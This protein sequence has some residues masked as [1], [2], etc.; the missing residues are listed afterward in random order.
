MYDFLS[1]GFSRG[2]IRQVCEAL[3][4][5]GLS[6][7]I[8]LF[9]REAL[10]GAK[11]VE[12]DDMALTQVLEREIF[13]D[14]LLVRIHRYFWWT[15]LAPWE[16]EFP[17]PGSLISTFLVSG[18]TLFRA[19]T[20]VLPLLLPLLWCYL[21]IALTQVLPFWPLLRCYLFGPHSGAT[22]LAITEVLPFLKLRYPFCSG[23]VNFD[24]T[25]IL[26]RF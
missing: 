16:F 18:A 12:L 23:E 19:W 9:R 17:F 13:F 8:N 20:Q 26:S 22:F 15:V 6:L 11:L 3:A 2:I 7:Y 25:E 14:N 21:C 10:D 24:L 1:L 4:A 5:K